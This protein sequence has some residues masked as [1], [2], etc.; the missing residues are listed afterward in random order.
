VVN[1]VYRVVGTI[2]E[3][4]LLIT[5]I[6]LETVQA[7]E[8]VLVGVQPGSE[9]EFITSAGHQMAVVVVPLNA[10]AVRRL[11][12][13]NRSLLRGVLRPVTVGELQAA[14]DAAAP[15]PQAAPDGTAPTP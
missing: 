4:P 1:G 7:S 13:G 8:N 12:S 14:R 3:F 11:G 9:R 10:A 6:P 15:A 5:S 2:S